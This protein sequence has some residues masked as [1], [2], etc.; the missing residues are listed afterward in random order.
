M[1]VDLETA[2][3]QFL[4]FARELQEQSAL[5]TEAVLAR[6]LAF[7]R[8]VRVLGADLDADG[9]MLLLQ[10]GIIAPLILDEP[11]D[12]RYVQDDDEFED[13]FKFEEVE[14]RYL[15][16]TR[17][18]FAPEEEDDDGTAFDAEAVQLSLMLTYGPANG[19]EPL[20]NQW[21]HKPT[22]IEEEITGFLRVPF[23]AQHFGVKPERLIATVDGCG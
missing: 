19:D 6:M 12:L 5:T 16:F 23:V 13:Q 2:I 9:D 11:V 3:E 1:S 18:I 4:S 7:Y 10:W 22:E 20:A 17:Q 15:D 21:I 8:D 14:Q